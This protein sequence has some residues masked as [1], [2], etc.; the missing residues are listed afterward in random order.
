MGWP[1]RLIF[2]IYACFKATAKTKQS[3]IPRYDEEEEKKWKKQ[4]GRR[5]RTED[6][7]ALASV[8]DSQVPLVRTI[9]RIPDRQAK[10][11]SLIPR[12]NFGE[13]SFQG[14]SQILFPV[15]I[16]CVVPNPSLNFIRLLRV[17]F[18]SY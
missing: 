14:S 3:F 6:T 4:T 7:T 8:V 10:K 5:H 17:V 9:A 12:P 11:N 16:F 2:S 1:F 15:K 18:F 13:S